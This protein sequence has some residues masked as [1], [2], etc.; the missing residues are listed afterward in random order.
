[1]RRPR[2]SSTRGSPTASRP[3]RAGVTL[4]ELLLVMMILGI[5]LGGGLGVFAALDLGRRQALGVV[6]NAVRG[7]QN[8]ALASSS[9]ARVLLD[10]E[11]GT[12][13][14]ESLRVIGTWHFENQR[15]AGAFGLDGAAPNA[16][17]G[18][19]WLGDGLW[20][21]GR[22][23]SYA[24]IPV[25]HAP[26]FDLTDGFSV[27]CVVL[28]SAMGGGKILQIGSVVAL[29]TNPAGAVRGKFTTRIEHEGREQ[30]G[31]EV[32]VESPPDA[33]PAERWTRIELEYDRLRLSLFVDGIPVASI[34]ERARVW[35]VDDRLLLSDP[36]HAFEG[37]IDCL[38][39]RA[40]VREEPVELAD[41]VRFAPGTPPAVVFDAGGRL[42]RS[43]HPDPVFLRLAFDDGTSAGFTV[44]AYGVIE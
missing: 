12:V 22:A 10:A 43:V 38:V 29:L 27:E 24:E 14:V 11:A 4:L 25:E 18:E 40:M 17:F 36:R 7:A 35:P 23:D 20:F 5:V 33:L 37:A 8:S 1:M 2:P 3:A 16:R 9:P 21:S 28:R 34:E 15:L 31:G 19:G 26:S 6:K 13:A 41:S 30:K 44:G 39:I 32:F 42:D